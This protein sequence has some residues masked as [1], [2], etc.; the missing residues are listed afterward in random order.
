MILYNKSK[1]E[2]LK[3]KFEDSEKIEQNYSQAYQDMFVLSMLNGK[4]NGTFLEIG[5]WNPIF[6][7]NSF[8]LEKEFGWNGISID[9]EPGV[10]QQHKNSRN[11]T[12]ILDNAL[13]INYE[14]LLLQYDFPKQID[15]L[16]LDIEPHSKTLA[17]LKLLP[18]DKYRFSVITF[19][20]DFY[21]KISEGEEMCHRV[22][23]ESREIL[24]SKGYVLVAGNICNI[25]NE[26]AFE[27]WYI[28]P[29]VI[30]EE[31]YK[32]FQINHE[33]NKPGEQLFL[34]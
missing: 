31:I 7:N 22:L 21:D 33:F 4:K 6:L 5:A 30:N 16:S 24:L 14:N 2:N 9:I 27:D 13:N 18:L 1:Y 19:E 29:L 12:F 8:L 20:T 34:L 26:D 28:D 11:N 25:S 10:E 15:Y 3:F 32:K 23:N 17:C